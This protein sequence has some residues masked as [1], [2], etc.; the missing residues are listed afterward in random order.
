LQNGHTAR[1]KRE[2]RQLFGRDGNRLLDEHGAPLA[3]A[4]LGLLDVPPRGAADTDAVDV[5]A[6]ER[7]HARDHASAAQLGEVLGPGRV[8]V[9]H[10]RDGNTVGAK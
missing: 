8:G 2:T 1:Q 6:R 9:E 10:E 3:G 7:V 5:C 4:A